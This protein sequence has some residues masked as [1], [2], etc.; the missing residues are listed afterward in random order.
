MKRLSALTLPVLPALSTLT[1]VENW[2]SHW[3]VFGLGF[4]GVLLASFES[5]HMRDKKIARRT[6]ISSRAQTR[7]RNLEEPE[8]LRQHRARELDPEYIGLCMPTNTMDADAR[9]FLGEEKDL[10]QDVDQ[11]HEMAEGRERASQFLRDQLGLSEAS[12][13]TVCLRPCAAVAL[14]DLLTSISEAGEGV[15][16]PTPFDAS[17][18]L[19]HGIA[20]AD[21][22]RCDAMATG[23]W[24]G[25]INASLRPAILH[26]SWCAARE[27]GVHVRAL[28]ISNPDQVT[29]RIY[30]SSTLDQAL[31]WCFS[32]G[33]HF[34]VDA[35]LAT[36]VHRPGA[37]S[38]AYKP[39]TDT[40]TQLSTTY[41]RGKLLHTLYSFTTFG[42][43]LGSCTVLHTL[44]GSLLRSCS[45][46]SSSSHELTAAREALHLLAVPRRVRAALQHHRRR[47][48][49]LY[50]GIT[51]LLDRAGLLYVQAEAGAV[52]LLDLRRIT[53]SGDSSA[54]REAELKAW[55]D[56]L[57]CHHICL[58]P[59]FTLSFDSAGWFQ[60]CF[61]SSSEEALS[62]AVAAI[63]TYAAG[64]SGG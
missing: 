15:L 2:E 26:E 7:L 63:C 30:H 46:L 50:L 13:K 6:A 20:L 38:N 37:M 59:G 48:R 42:E 55:W 44:N 25:D 21:V 35:S 19:G 33:L 53:K 18:E 62:K 17:G 54:R 12:E 14:R 61:G 60:L 45:G 29:G 10:A 5:L 51:H 43:P 32:V 64:S 57:E 1:D 56:L 11:G 36:S 16:V 28:L 8:Y 3:I 47:L 27:K 31:D 22:L 52:V 39:Q 23:V 24:M 34:I 40:T 41:S 49:E 58:V 4:L 9:R